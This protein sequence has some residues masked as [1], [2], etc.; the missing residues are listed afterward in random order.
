MS[1]ADCHSSPKALSICYGAELRFW[2]SRG[3]KQ[4]AQFLTESGLHIVSDFTQ[5]LLAAGVAFS[6]FRL[7]LILVVAA[8]TTMVPFSVASAVG[9]AVIKERAFRD[10]RRKSDR[11][12]ELLA[13][14]VDVIHE[15]DH[16]LVGRRLAPSYV[17]A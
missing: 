4:E 3:T 1:L 5:R 15:A 10:A 7:R 11:A 13:L 8:R 2:L 17:D 12:L 16:H 6:G 14:V 9:G